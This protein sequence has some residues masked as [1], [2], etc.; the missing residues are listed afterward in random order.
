MGRRT[1]GSGWKASLLRMMRPWSCQAEGGALEA[2]AAASLKERLGC[3]DEPRDGGQA[4]EAEG[5]HSG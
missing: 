5:W 1:V 4:R 3:R 2:E